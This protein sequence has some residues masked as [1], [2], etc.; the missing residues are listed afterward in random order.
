[1]SRDK[2]NMASIKNRKKLSMSGGSVYVCACVRV[3]V[4]G[5]VAREEGK[6]QVTHS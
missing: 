6:G 5:V 3:C 1:M 4:R 2:E